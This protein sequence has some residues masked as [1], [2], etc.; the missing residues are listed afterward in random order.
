MSNEWAYINTTTGEIRDI[1]SKAN[2][3]A[4]YR[5]KLA[6]EARNGRSVD[7]TSAN[8]AHIHEV[9]NVLTTA[10]CGYL[11]LLQCYVG[12]NEGIIVN[13]DKSP[14]TTTDMLNVLKLHRK[15]STFYN[16]LKACVD[17]AIIS[18][19][20]DGSYAV[21]ERYHFKGAFNDRQVVKAYSTKVK[22]VYREVKARDIGLIYRMLPYVHMST[23]ALC[24]DPFEKDPRK[25]VWF[26]RDS[27]AKAIGVNPDTLGK[28]LK[29]MRFDGEA[30]IHRGKLLDGP[31]RYTLNPSVFYRQDKEPSDA[32]LGMFSGNSTE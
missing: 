25:I 24:V 20:A 26:T 29:L 2:Q 6:K 10:Q 9:Y 22:R 32:L 17:N 16:F 4:G 19:L 28:R 18:E 1:Q 23:N 15:R 30:V 14:M 7:F 13:A 5:E 11:M 31:D 3:A 21:N 12:W 8:M 27:L